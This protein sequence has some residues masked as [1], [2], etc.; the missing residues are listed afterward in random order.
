MLEFSGIYII[1]S[2]SKPQ[3]VYIGSA[4]NIESRKLLHL[5]LLR[6]GNHHSIKLQRHYNKYGEQ[7]LDFNVIH[8]CLSEELIEAEQYFIDNY[9]PYFNI[10]RIAGS[11]LG[12]VVTEKTKEKLRVA[13][14]GKKLSPMKDEVRA[15]ISNRMVGNTHGKGN[16]GKVRTSNMK[17]KSRQSTLAFFNTLQGERQKQ[18][19]R[20]INT[21]VKQSQETIDKRV[22][23]L[24]EIHTT[25]E[26]KKKMSDTMK[27]RPN[28]IC[29]YCRKYCSFTDYHCHHGKKCK[30][31]T[32]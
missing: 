19:N 9:K 32:N 14:T 18:L 31:K 28:K 11:R 1:R 12:H 5:H 24:K 27:E 21:G 17:E 3:R 23:K 6:K 15:L 7:D 13:H 4:K 8:C 30:Q 25:P 22:K 2:T 20:E 10:C 16:K 29:E 26:Y